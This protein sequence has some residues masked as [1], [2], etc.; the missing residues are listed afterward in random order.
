MEEGNDYSADSIDFTSMILHWMHQWRL[1]ALFMIFGMGTVF[2]SGI[3]PTV[4]FFSNERM[5][6]CSNVRNVTMVLSV[7]FC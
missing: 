4:Y 7:E 6:D 5:T 1:A 2:A 3:E